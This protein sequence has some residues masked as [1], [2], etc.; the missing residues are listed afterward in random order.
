MTASI[1]RVL[2]TLWLPVPTD[3]AGAVLELVGR[4]Y[5]NATL[6]NV[7][8]DATVVAVIVNELVPD[9]DPRLVQG[10]AVTHHLIQPGPAYDTD[11]APSVTRPGPRDWTATYGQR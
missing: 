11:D 2:I 7:N 9:D 8:D 10:R 6:E 4:H 3:V 1:R 5:P